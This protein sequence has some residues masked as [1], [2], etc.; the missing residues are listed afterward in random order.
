MV[1]K[2]PIAPVLQV[3]LFIL[4]ILNIL[5]GLSF[6]PEGRCFNFIFSTLVGCSILVGL[7]YLRKNN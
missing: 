6:L 3:F 1:K 5:V 4:A 2:E 7:H